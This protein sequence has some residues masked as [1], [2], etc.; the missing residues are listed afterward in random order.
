MTQIS[1]VSFQGNTHTI[2]SLASGTT[3]IKELVFVAGHSQTNAVFL[4]PAMQGAATLVLYQ[5]WF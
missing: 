2:T 3:G 5:A 1:Y 4:L